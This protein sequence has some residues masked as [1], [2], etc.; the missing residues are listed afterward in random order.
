MTTGAPKWLL[1]AAMVAS[2]AVFFG[3]LL[4]LPLTRHAAGPTPDTVAT[5][6]AGRVSPPSTPATV[7]PPSPAPTTPAPLPDPAILATKLGKVSRTGLGA[8]GIVVIDPATGRTL[9]SRGDRPLIPAST[10]KLLTTLAAL[11]TLGPDRRLTTSVV[12][13]K[14]GQ[15]V[16]VGGGDPT[17][18]D[19]QSKSAARPASL[20]S[21]AKATIAALRSAGV[22]KVSVGYDAYLFPGPSYS[23]D[24][25]A[26]WKSFTARVSALL[27]N[28]GK[29]DA[30]HAAPNPPRAAAEAFAARLR[31]GGITVTGVSAAKGRGVTTV[32]AE[33]QSAP[34]SAIVA[35][36][37]R[38]SDNVAAEVLARHVALATGRRGDFAGASAALKTWLRDRGL[39][40]SGMRIVD[41]SGISTRAAVSPSVL[42]RAIKLALDDT[43]F[44]SV[45]DGLPVAGVSGTL[46]DRFADPPEKPGRKV[47]HAKT[48]T[49]PGVAALAGWVT[50]RDGAKLVFAAMV[51]KSTSKTAAFNWTDRSA[52]VLATCGCR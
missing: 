23:A 7:T 27:V 49:L 52:S 15:L 39:W 44:A 51:N 13:P 48:G 21:L 35:H 16:L 50:T 37:L 8:T 28:S 38:Y 30:W 47:V 34:L 18:T 3:S 4:L 10:L 17:L 32:L 9:A 22:K 20:Q 33:V 26:P 6:A 24:W 29:L 12:S 42:A 41:G 14:R 46:K 2:T 36:T 11:D 25:P 43:R 45:L 19:K 40:V 5:S 31:A 1:P